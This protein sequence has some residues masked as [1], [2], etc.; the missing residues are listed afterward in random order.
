M[1][2]HLYGDRAGVRFLVGLKKKP[3]VRGCDGECRWKEEGCSLRS[4]RFSTRVLLLPLIRKEDEFGVVTMRLLC[5]QPRHVVAPH[6]QSDRLAT[7]LLQENMFDVH[8]DGDAS[9]F[10]ASNNN[11]V[12]SLS[13]PRKMRGGLFVSPMCASERGF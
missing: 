2:L 3:G 9:C 5:V 8:G 11:S 12:L 1:C 7:P 6:H 4:D 10:A 13:L